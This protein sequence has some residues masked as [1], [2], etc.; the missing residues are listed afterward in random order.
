MS[1]Q[2]LAKNLLLDNFSKSLK[3]PYAQN[4]GYW[5]ARLRI[6]LC[7]HL[8]FVVVDNEYT[9]EHP[10]PKST[11]TCAQHIIPSEGDI[12]QPP[13]LAAAIVGYDLC[14][15]VHA[16]VNARAVTLRRPVPAF[17]GILKEMRMQR[18]REEDNL[19]LTKEEKLARLERGK[20][21]IPIHP[22]EP[23]HYLVIRNGQQKENARTMPQIGEGMDVWL[24]ATRHEYNGMHLATSLSMFIAAY[25]KKYTNFQYLTLES[26]HPAT[27]KIWRKIGATVQS[28]AKP[29]EFEF[30]GPDGP[31]FPFSTVMYDM[32]TLDMPLKKQ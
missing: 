11:C 14:T 21:K 18:I 30:A 24:L 25:A 28:R 2:Y 8:S 26:A 9:D 1:L 4:I 19:L 5:I 13:N 32:C 22:S 23:H 7:D 10:H 17:L 6:C 27:E 15:T 12:F 16:M 29:S 20:E 3:N 31:T